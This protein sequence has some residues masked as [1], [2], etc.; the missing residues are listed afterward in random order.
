MCPFSL[1]VSRSQKYFA[2]SGALDQTGVDFG[3]SFSP[4]GGLWSMSGWCRGYWSSQGRV[5]K[6][7]N[8]VAECNNLR[9]RYTRTQECPLPPLEGLSKLASGA[10]E[11]GQTT[12]TCKTES[13]QSRAFRLSYDYH[14]RG[15]AMR[16]ALQIALIWIFGFANGATEPCTGPSRTGDR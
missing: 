8:W 11:M 14:C 4:L 5:E 12:E 3:G 13:G 6:G 15:L 7:W 16:H 2:C 9:E 1:Y 10:S